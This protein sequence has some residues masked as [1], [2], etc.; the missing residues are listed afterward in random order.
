MN[1]QTPLDFLAEKKQVDKTIA[2]QR[3]GGKS[4]DTRSGLRHAGRRE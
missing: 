1:T 3:Q 2:R 4:H